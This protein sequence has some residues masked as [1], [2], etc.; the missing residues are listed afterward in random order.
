[1]PGSTIQFTLRADTSQGVAALEKMRL[2]LS[3]VGD[4]AENSQK[5]AASSSQGFG[6]ALESVK[7]I[8]AGLAVTFG[9]LQL[10]QQIEHWTGKLIDFQTEFAKVTTLFEGSPEVYGAL[11]EQLLSLGGE[12][13]S[14]TQLA[15][16]LYATIQSGDS[17]ADAIHYVKQTARLSKTAIVDTASAVDLLKVSQNA[18]GKSTAEVSQ[19][20]ETLFRI[21]RQ[22]GGMDANELAKGLGRLASVAAGLNIPLADLGAVLSTLKQYQIPVTQGATLLTTLFTKMSTEGS[23][24]NQQLREMGVDLNADTFKN[25]GIINVLSK[26]GT[27]IQGDTALANELGLQGRQVN[28]FLALAGAGAQ[29]AALAFDQMTESGNHML[30]AHGRME[31]TLGEKW[32][33]MMSNLERSIVHNTGIVDGLTSAVDSLGKVIVFTAGNFD[34]LKSAAIA[35]LTVWAGFKITSMIGEWDNFGKVIA[36]AGNNMGG[37]GKA[38]SVAGAAILGWNIG[39]WIADLTG[40]DEALT[41]LWDK[42]GLFQGRVKE[43]QQMSQEALRKEAEALE[44]RARSLN[45]GADQ[46]QYGIDILHRSGWEDPQK[47]IDRIKPML[48]AYDQVQ[49]LANRQVQA[50]A[51]AADSV[52]RLTEEEKKL[53]E[54]WLK[55][56]QPMSAIT[57][58][59]KKLAAVGATVDQYAQAHWKDIVKATEAQK[60]FGQPLSALDEELYNSA[61]A[62]KRADDAMK[63]WTESLKHIK[64]EEP[65]DTVSAVQELLNQT[66][67]DIDKMKSRDPLKDAFQLPSKAEMDKDWKAFNDVFVGAA[68]ETKDE[69]SQEISTIFNDWIKGISDAI[70]EWKGFWQTISQVA[71][72]SVKGLLRTFLDELLS[73]LKDEM[74]KLGKSLSDWITGAGKSDSGEESSGPSSTGLFGLP[75]GGINGKGVG[76]IAGGLMTTGGIMAYMDSINRD[77]AAGWV[78]GIGGGALAGLAI[79]GPIGAAIGAAVG[80][81]TKGVQSLV[82]AIQGKTSEQA[83]SMEVARD[84]GGINI[85]T[86]Q[87]KS[88]YES[89]G[90]TDSSAYDIRKDISSSPTFLVNTLYPLAQAQ[91]K[92]NE[93]LQSLEQVKT[94]WGTFN[95]RSAFELGQATGDWT[96][97]NKQFAE[98]FKNSAALQQNLPNW[99]DVLM[100]PSKAVTDLQNLQQAVKSLIP[101]TNSLYDDFVKTGTVTDELAAKIQELGGNL[102]KFKDYA[103]LTKEDKTWTDLVQHFKDT[104]EIL[105]DLIT[106]YEKWGGDME[107]LNEAAALPGLHSSLN[108]ITE[109]Q[110]ELEKLAPTMDPVQKLLNGTWDQDVVDAFTNAGLDPDKFKGIAGIGTNMNGWDQAVSDFQSSGVLTDAMRQA[111]I[112]YGGTAGQTAVSRYDQGFNTI[113]SG[114]LA[115]TKA[116]MDQAYQDKVKELLGDLATAQDKTT[117][118]IQTL[119]DSMMGAF[120]TVGNK[121]SDAISAAAT[122]VVAEI[123]VML[124]NL[125]TANTGADASGNTGVPVVGTG[126]AGDT[127]DNGDTGSQPKMPTVNVTI[128]GDVYGA[129]DFNQKVA[130]AFTTVWRNGGFAYIQ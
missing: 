59:Y 31:E 99:A 120:D 35:F 12:F 38:A 58:E 22:G 77:G 3:D 82:S 19:T 67:E 61:L 115:D 76:G 47:Y 113:S 13:G 54:Q 41:K 30:D 26:L 66:V 16:T 7:G 11:R 33:K 118:Q 15:K 24:L 46:A 104:G 28:A 55:E 40:A 89:L 90:L 39:R 37:F 81:F 88:F 78:E 122:A 108:F 102:E 49:K 34:T 50:H 87:F 56:I 107:K 86:D 4:Q 105:P 69:V 124:Q 126:G 106:L 62:W 100:A 51:A 18:Y 57:D 14:N 73:P 94:S 10:A 130:Q 29:K 109:L 119:T 64:Q 42:L 17:S 9:G 95:F 128:N 97:L 63:S 5:R 80:A 116:A 68:K 27:V 45:I 21:L 96:E 60:E 93:F 92:V 110:G 129:D 23:K 85:S 53:Q 84:F 123:D 91:G 114:L 25:G 103:D 8:V 20:A 72:D 125:K 2:A 1:M 36:T 111:L 71:K 52:H 112:Q 44:K 127:G 83:G 117:S 43:M 74:K 6:S 32:D 70:V 48:D 65:A 98:A 75:A 121:I 101:T 79:A